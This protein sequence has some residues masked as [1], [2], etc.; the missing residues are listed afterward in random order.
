VDGRRIEQ[1]LDNLLSNALKFTPPGGMVRVGARVDGTDAVLSVRDSGL[2][3]PADERDRIFE[4]FSRAPS[5]VRDQVPGSGLG[6]AVCRM[7]VERHGGHIEVD[8]EEGAGTTVLVR[9]PLEPATEGSPG[10]PE[11]VGS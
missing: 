1:V 8:S 9:L 6:L 5:A 2:G 11:A 3:I 10:R 4:R 7:I